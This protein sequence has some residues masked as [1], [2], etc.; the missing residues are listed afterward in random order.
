[1]AT[2]AQL[3]TQYNRAKRL[4][5]I[6]HFKDAEKEVTKGYTFHFDAATLM[7]IASRES[8]LDPKW[9]TKQ[10]DKGDGFGLMQADRRSFPEFAKSDAW[11]DARAGIIFGAGVLVNKF[12]DTYSG[13][14]V[15]RTVKS[16]KNGKV[17]SFVGK[18][19]DSVELHRVAIAAYN[20]GR[21]AH[22]AV[23]MG[24]DVDT[25]TTDN[26]DPDKKGEYSADVLARARV[27]RDLLEQD[28]HTVSAGAA[29]EQGVSTPPAPEPQK[30]PVPPAESIKA[31]ETDIKT[32][33]PS[34]MTRV[35]A[36][37]TVVAG[38]FQTLGIGAGT[39]LTNKINDLPA[40]VFWWAGLGVVLVAVGI[41]LY[42]RSSERA[43]DRNAME[44][45][46]IANPDKKATYFTQ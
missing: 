40:S 28:G 10:G 11:K 44:H 24:K 33:R 42:D 8:N 22:Y 15:K 4:G 45:E 17:Y 30:P 6:A 34:M 2:R 26:D 32:N 46:S 31:T 35:I 14:G 16:S 23:S 5:W 3:V 36:G 43:H 25:Y 41:W 21:W 12:H 38:V 20:C 29:K 19:L 9:L 27:F 37:I 13:M 1:M 7:G 18:E 39:I